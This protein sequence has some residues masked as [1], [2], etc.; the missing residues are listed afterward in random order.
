MSGIVSRLVSA[1]SLA[2]LLSSCA[3]QIQMTCMVPSRVGLQKGESLAIQGK[4]HLGEKVQGQLSRELQQGGFYTIKENAD[5]LLRLDKVRENTLC[6][7][8]GTDDDDEVFEETELS[9]WVYLSRKEGGA[10]GYAHKYAITTDG[11]SGDVEELCHDIARDLQPHRLIYTEKLAAPEGNPAFEQAADYCKAGMWQHAARAAEAAV[12]QTPHEPE[13]HYL[14]GLIQRQLENY[15]AS[16]IC[17]DKAYQLRPDTRYAEASKI[18]K[19]MQM[20]ARYVRHQMKFNSSEGAA[21]N[22]GT[23][24]AY[25]KKEDTPWSHL[26]F[27][28]PLKFHTQP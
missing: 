2:V 18:N 9:T 28:Y 1:F 16:D 17:F 8:T 26:F 22:K 19:L 27:H 3:V 15:T 20:G 21:F 7:H 14:Q 24:P 12:Q 23:L 6:Y 13:A 5:Y 10:Y 11:A 25:H 4:T